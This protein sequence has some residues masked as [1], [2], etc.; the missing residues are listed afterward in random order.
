[1]RRAGG[2]AFGA[3]LGEALGAPGQEPEP[4]QIAGLEAVAFG[5]PEASAVEA[6]AGPVGIMQRAV[7]DDPHE[8]EGGVRHADLAGFPVL[9]G[10]LGDAKKLRRRRDGQQAGQPGLAEAERRHG[11]GLCLPQRTMQILTS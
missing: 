10:A 5:R 2:V 6:E 3:E 4:R 11:A 9:D 8:P 1:M 7:A